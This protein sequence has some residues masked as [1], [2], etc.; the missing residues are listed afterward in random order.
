MIGELSNPLLGMRFFERMS[1]VEIK[2][3]TRTVGK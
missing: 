3:S 1:T 2:K